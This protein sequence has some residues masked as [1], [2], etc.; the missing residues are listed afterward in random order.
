MRSE[1]VDITGNKLSDVNTLH[2]N[3]LYLYHQLGTT[4]SHQP[5]AALANH[6]DGGAEVRAAAQSLGDGSAGCSASLQQA[7]DDTTQLQRRLERRLAEALD[8][9]GAVCGVVR[10][11]RRQG[12]QTS[13][14]RKVEE[15]D[16]K[17]PGDAVPPSCP[18]PREVVRV[19]VRLN[20]KRDCSSTDVS[21]PESMKKMHREECME[22][23][24]RFTR[25]PAAERN[26]LLPEMLLKLSSVMP[27]MADQSATVVVMGEVVKA[28]KMVMN[29]ALNDPQDPNLL[30][31][32]DEFVQD[33]KLYADMLPDISPK[34]ELT[35]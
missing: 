26:A 33:M 11:E 8:G 13:K 20:E 23:M 3:W 35:R 16:V 17:E 32:Y 24:A 6:G 22:V 14:R 7:L 27:Q 15:T 10:T 1:Q 29:W 18:A 21:I 4:A 12:E 9:M 28:A 31:L 2:F 30:K 5:V 34:V 19:T 25:L